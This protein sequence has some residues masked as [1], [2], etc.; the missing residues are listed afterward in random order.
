MKSSCSWIRRGGGR[1]A[2]GTALRSPGVCSYPVHTHEYQYR[3]TNGN[4]IGRIELRTFLSLYFLTLPLQLV[5]TGACPIT[6]RSACLCADRRLHRV[7]LLGSFLEQGSTPLVV[8]TAIHAGVVAAL[9]WSLL[10][11]GLVAT[12]VVED[13][14]PSSLIPF[15]A[16]A[17]AFFAA[18]TYIS[19]DIGLGIT[20][21]FGPSKPL[22][23]LGSI[24]L[25]VLT[26]IWPAA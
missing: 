17:L 6:S 12:Q 3:D 10:A 22:E 1:G 20:S 11:N 5:T 8:V 14:T 4:S 13:G 7:P 16:L 2:V 21:V 15:Y 18:T 26:S 19:L 24:P 9:F 25:F 23:S